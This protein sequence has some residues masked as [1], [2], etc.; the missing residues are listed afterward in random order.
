M[1]RRD[2]LRTRFFQVLASVVVFAE[3]W[4]VGQ[5]TSARSP[6]RCTDYDPSHT[7]HGGHETA[8]WSKILTQPVQSLMA[9][10]PLFSMAREYG[11]KPYTSDSRKGTPGTHG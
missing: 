8:M 3:W 9:V 4:E 1:V 5:A 7:S 10:R 11:P 6:D 2:V